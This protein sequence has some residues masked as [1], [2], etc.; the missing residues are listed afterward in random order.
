MFEDAKKAIMN[1]SQSSSVYVGADSIR[2]KKNKKW[3][4]KYS[5]VIILHKD[6]RHGCQIFHHTVDLEDYGNLKQRLLTE[7]QFAV[8]A[9]TD[10]LEVLGGRHMS[11]HLDINPNPK[12]KSNVAVKEAL[13]WVKGCLGIDAQIKPLAWAATHAADHVVR[14]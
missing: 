12:H 1:S 7:V 4:A 5:T 14:H 6:S 11:V 2:Y 3:M 13:G 8:D 10:I 9:A